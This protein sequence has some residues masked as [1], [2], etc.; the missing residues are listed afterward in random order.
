MAKPESVRIKYSV[1]TSG[2]RRATKDLE[3]MVALIEKLKNYGVKV[4]WNLSMVK[5]KGFKN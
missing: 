3:K 1:D 4:K 5:S 2:V